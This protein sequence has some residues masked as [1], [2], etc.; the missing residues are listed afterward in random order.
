MQSQL[1]GGGAG[2]AGRAGEVQVKRDIR[3][4]MRIGWRSIIIIIAALVSAACDS[5]TAGAEQWPVTCDEAAGRAL[6]KMSPEFKQRVRALTKDQLIILHDTWGTGIRNEF[7]LWRGNG[8]LLASCAAEA[9][10]TAPEPDPVAMIIITRTWALLQRDKEG[11]HGG[12]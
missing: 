10:G 4:P 6:A 7:G 2:A 8:P 3:S 12:H 11:P 1:E 9:E 5:P